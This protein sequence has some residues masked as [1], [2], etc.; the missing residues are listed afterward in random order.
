LLK[1]K[2]KRE[3]KKKKEFLFDLQYSVD[4]R[5]PPNTLPYLPTY[6]PTH[7]PILKG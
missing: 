3:R 4:M 7:P 5:A 1:K 2:R 6:L